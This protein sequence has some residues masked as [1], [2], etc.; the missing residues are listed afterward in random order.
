MNNFRE[1]YHREWNHMPV[2][3][4]DAAK[5]QEKLCSEPKVVVSKQHKALWGT[6]AAC[7]VLL[8]TV[9]TTVAMDYYSSDITVGRGGFA[10]LGRKAADMAAADTV[11]QPAA[12][13]S[14]ESNAQIAMV[15]STSRRRSS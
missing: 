5:L 14:E 9:G 7:F 3:H 4:L 1:E 13:Q 10:F 6:C 15:S 2:F 12:V 11:E 8:C